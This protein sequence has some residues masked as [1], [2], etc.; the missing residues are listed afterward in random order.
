MIDNLSTELYVF[1]VHTLISLLVDKI[2][3][4]RYVN[5]PYHFRV[6]PLK[7]KNALSCLKHMNYVLFAFSWRSIT[8]AACSRLCDQ[9]SPFVDSS[10]YFLFPLLFPSSFFLSFFLSF[11]PLPL[12]SSLFCSLPI[13]TDFYRYCVS[14]KLFLKIHFP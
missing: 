1:T 12:I 8:P 3:R 14:P 9:D 13:Q 6:L 4:K 5:R 7:D 10:P 2:L 11:L